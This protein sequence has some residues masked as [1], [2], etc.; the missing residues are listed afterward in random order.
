MDVGPSDGEE[1]SAA[2]YDRLLVRIEVGYL[3]DTSNFAALV[4]SAV[5]RPAHRHGPR[6]S[7]A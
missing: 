2:I 4:R 5:S 7:C 6:S 3:E 1:D